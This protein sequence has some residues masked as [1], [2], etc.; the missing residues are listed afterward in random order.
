MN[1]RQSFDF[2]MLKNMPEDKLIEECVSYIEQYLSKEESIQ[3]KKAYDDGKYEEAKDFLKKTLEKIVASIK[4]SEL[5]KAKTIITSLLPLEEFPEAKTLFKAIDENG[6][7]Q[8]NIMD[9]NINVLIMIFIAIIIIGIIGIIG[10][11]IYLKNNK[12][13]IG[14][15]LSFSCKKKSKNKKID[16]TQKD[17]DML[18]LIHELSVI[19][20]NVD[21]YMKS[22]SISND[23]E[24][25]KRNQ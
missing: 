7:R 14:D 24:S 10:V 19:Y 23:N 17:I 22:K 1:S 3:F 4:N 2:K 15:I 25:N 6:E 5:Q 12:K 13:T 21:G 11:A 18:K 16:Y 8:N 20:D 9:S